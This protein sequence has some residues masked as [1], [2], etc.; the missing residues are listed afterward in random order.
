MSNSEP[1][2]QS[3]S[4]NANSSDQQSPE[5][6]PSLVQ[7]FRRIIGLLPSQR[8]KQFWLLV[9]AALVTS[10]LE[11][12]TVGTIALFASAVS[13]PDVVMKSQY[14]LCAK[15]LLPL[16]FLS[17]GNDLIIT[18]SIVIVGLVLSKNFTQAVFIYWN[19]RYSQFVNGFYGK[20]L[21]EG[22]LRM[23]YTFHLSRNS[24]DLVIAT[25]WRNHFGDT[26]M[27]Y[28]LLLSDA[29]IVALLI[30]S[31]IILQ[32][33]VSLL[34][35][36]TI[37]TSSCFIYTKMKTPLDKVAK[38]AFEY[39]QIINRQ[40]SRSLHGIKDIKSYGEEDFFTLSYERDITILARL[41]AL[42]RLFANTPNWIVECIGIFMLNLSIC[43]MLFL[44]DLSTLET[45]GTIA[46][47]A[48]TT[49]R[50]LPAANRIVSNLTNIRSR[51]PHVENGFEYI[52]QFDE[53]S[54]DVP[55]GSET[56]ISLQDEIKF[57][58]VSFTYESANTP[59]LEQLNFTIPKGKSIGIVGPSGAGKSTLVDILTGLLQPSA[60]HLLIDGKALDPSQYRLW[61]HS[62]G[63]I[64]QSPY[65]FDGT[66]AE[67]V[68]FALNAED[69]D[70][71][72][73]AKCCDMA[74]MDFLAKLPCGIDTVIGERGIMLSGGQRQRVAI[75]RA[76]YH[77][78]KVLIF[79]E[80]TS[81][82]DTRNEKAIQN[83]INSF[84]GRQTL[85]IIAH[86][87]KTV[88]NCDQVVWIDDGKLK[89]IGSPDEILPYY[90]DSQSTN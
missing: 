78:P 16:G 49:W 87:L 70:E 67:N 11:T 42:H 86:R 8:R 39:R 15:A 1:K 23:P 80:A 60:G 52:D 28:L 13:D 71:D 12:V 61:R 33:I 64:P 25:E 48:I 89:K 22:F 9:A 84:K 72:Q 21:L 44:L 6:R 38:S 35:I 51:L 77:N 69:I 26:V 34:I 40:A 75:A 50:V 47:L 31:I 4:P 83:T 27:F 66:V 32:P 62:I 56:E 2:P 76:L 53:H 5:Q 68:A 63:Y 17:T 36:A 88:E 85:I 19:I 20:I 46:L 82:L 3:G 10:C 55:S 74:A 7:I 30:S 41:D 58:A 24:A 54:N 73:V 57:D 18:L 90:V 65:I 43:I 37:G 79:D 81:A 59:A 29:L 14:I 45:T